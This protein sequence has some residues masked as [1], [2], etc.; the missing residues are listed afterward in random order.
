MHVARSV[1]ETFPSYETFRA[2][3]QAFALA[4][5]DRAC[6][7]R[8]TAVDSRMCIHFAAFSQLPNLINLILGGHHHF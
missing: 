3:C 7:T 8:L 5:L 1:T 6:S 4:L 2:N